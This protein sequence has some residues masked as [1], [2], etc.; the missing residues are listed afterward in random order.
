MKVEESADREGVGDPP[1]D[2]A[3]APRGVHGQ[4]VHVGGRGFFVS[5]P[6]RLHTSVRAEASTPPRLYLIKKYYF[7]IKCNLICFLVLVVEAD[8][9]DEELYE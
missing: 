9:N 2:L 7:L 1:C 5:S 8:V 4:G 3:S 6:P